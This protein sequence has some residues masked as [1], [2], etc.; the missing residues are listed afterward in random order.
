MPISSIAVDDLFFLSGMPVCSSLL[1]RAT[2]D[3][4]TRGWRGFGR[5]VHRRGGDRGGGAILTEA[6]GLR[7]L[8]GQTAHFIIGNLTLMSGNYTL[9]GVMCGD[10]LCNVNGSVWT[11]TWEARCYLVLAILSVTGLARPRWMKHVILP[12]SLAF[13]IAIHVPAVRALF[14]YGG[15]GALYLLD[16]WDRLWTMFALGT[17]AYLWRDRIHLSRIACLALFGAVV[18]SQRWLPVPHLAGLFTGYAVLCLGFLSAR[19]RAL[20]GRWPDYSYGIYIYAFPVMM[21]VA[22][23]LPTPGHPLLGLAT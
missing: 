8:G 17:A 3:F 10:T 20:S 22:A 14:A 19:G 7:Y 4:V 21:V 6:S 1:R 9:T 23:L 18:A 11:V 12:L 16:Q 15:D 5:T 2:G 13:A